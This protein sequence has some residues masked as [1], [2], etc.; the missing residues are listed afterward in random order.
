M[1]SNPFD[2][3][4]GDW[5]VVANAGGHHALWRPHLDV[6]KG[7]RIVHR[8]PDRDAALDH[9]EQNVTATVRTP[10]T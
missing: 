1:S 10:T 4:P 5:L 2:D 9:V 3:G 8:A 6:P 7:W